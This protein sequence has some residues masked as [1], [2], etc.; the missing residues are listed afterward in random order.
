MEGWGTP[1][2]L[3]SLIVN[4]SP[5]PFGYRHVVFGACVSLPVRTFSYANTFKYSL[6]SIAALIFVVVT[7]VIVE[8]GFVCM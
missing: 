7:L 8:A 1:L 5:A 4:R 3:G 6:S 2:G